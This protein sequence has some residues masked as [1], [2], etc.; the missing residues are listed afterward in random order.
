M[1]RRK[2][3]GNVLKRQSNHFRIQAIDHNCPPNRCID[4]YKLLW[5]VCYCPFFDNN[6]LAIK[7]CKGRCI[8]LYKLLWQVCYCRKRD[9][10]KLAIKVCKGRCID[11]EDSCDRWLVCGN[12]YF[13]VS[14]HCPETCAASSGNFSNNKIVMN[15]HKVI[16]NL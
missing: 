4:L 9:N 8:D 5:Q 10:N 16:S 12:D 11:L 3:Q 15:D 1:R 13:D 14:K 7:V 6:K 2:F